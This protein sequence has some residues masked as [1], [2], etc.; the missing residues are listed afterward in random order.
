MEKELGTSLCILYMEQP[1]HYVTIFTAVCFQENQ[2]VNG[3]EFDL[4]QR[5]HGNGSIVCCIDAGLG[6]DHMWL[7]IHNKSD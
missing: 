4:V 1:L 5:E 6:G 3:G 7:E 2:S